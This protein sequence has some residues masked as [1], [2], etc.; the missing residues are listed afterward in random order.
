M[1]R[2][3]RTRTPSCYAGY[4]DLKWR[5]EN[6][7]DDMLQSYEPAEIVKENYPGGILYPCKDSRPLWMVP[8]GVDF[9]G[10]RPFFFFLCLVLARRQV[11]RG[12]VD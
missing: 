3:R 2:G 12:K 4:G 11:R 10:G 6:G 7:I 1:S 5:K 8:A 9:Q